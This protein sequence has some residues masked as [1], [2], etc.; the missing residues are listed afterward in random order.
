MSKKYITGY[1]AQTRTMALRYTLSIAVL[2]L[3]VAIM[4]STVFSAFRIFG[5]VPDL[6]ICTV[7]IIAFF[8]GQYAGAITGI[9]AGWLIEAMGG[10]TGI[11]ILPVIYLLCGY[12]TGYFAKSASARRYPVY[13]IYLGIV[14]LLRAGTTVTYAC[15]SYQYIDLPKI[16]L[17][18]VLPEL[19]ATAVCGSL[20]YAPLKAFCV[21]VEK[22]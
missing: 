12:L 21:A 10:G 15:L 13:L 18:T 9:G 22:K 19:I 4:Q 17:Q 6:M 11:L 5:A 3:L 16:L 20:L 1:R 7:L 2:L 8:F 14:L